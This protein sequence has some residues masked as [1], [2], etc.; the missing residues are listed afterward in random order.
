MVDFT[1]KDVGMLGVYVFFCRLKIGIVS[2]IHQHADLTPKMTGFD[3]N[4]SWY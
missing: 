4:I 3:G 2:G 1:V